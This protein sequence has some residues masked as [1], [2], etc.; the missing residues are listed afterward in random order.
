MV[1]GLGGVQVRWAMG[2][3][4][5]SGYLWSRECRVVVHGPGGSGQVAHGLPPPLPVNRITHMSE[6]ITFPHTMHV[7]GN[8]S[9]LIPIFTGF[10]VISFS[11][12]YL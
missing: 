4:M 2:G 1:R 3:A 12:L 6:N 8:H 5:G 11:V 7:D 9:R 10:V